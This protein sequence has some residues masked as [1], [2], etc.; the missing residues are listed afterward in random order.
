MNVPRSIAD[1]KNP[2]SLSA[3]FR[4]RRGVLLKALLSRVS[5]RRAG[6]FRIL[7]LGGT[8]DY[9]RAIGIDFLDSIDAQI[10]V[11]NLHPGELDADIGTSRI[12]TIV[13]NACAMDM[14]DN[15]FDFVH[16]NSVIEHVGR[17]SDMMA[18]AREVSRLAPSYYV[19]T[20]YYWFPVDPHFHRVPALH[21]MPVPVQVA[22]LRRFRLGHSAP[23]PDIAVTTGRIES[24]SILTATQFRYLFPDAE[25]RFEKVFGLP[26]SMIAIRE[27]R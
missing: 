11:A 19:Q 1:P 6:P 8:P 18:F 15:S 26:K 27:V 25:H 20:P 21:W 12:T 24:R 13:G 14:A 9:W 23:D 10:A 3:K 4:A 7:D 5:A 2:K 17:F 16:S 22:L